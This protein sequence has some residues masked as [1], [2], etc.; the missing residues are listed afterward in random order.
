MGTLSVRYGYLL[1]RRGIIISDAVLP[2]LYYPGMHI[3][4]PCLKRQPWEPTG[5][6][7]QAGG[8][9]GT[10]IASGKERQRQRYASKDGLTTTACYT[11]PRVNL[12]SHLW[13]PI[14]LK[15]CYVWYNVGVHVKRVGQ[16]SC[17][18]WG[19]QKKRGQ[20]I[21]RMILYNRGPARVKWGRCVLEPRKTMYRLN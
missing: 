21:G 16:E 4:S 2:P 1:N 8:T 7:V 9:G 13:S 10:N 15:V 3:K 20:V 12:F 18:V 17:V 11:C 6:P 14:I 19:K 5:V